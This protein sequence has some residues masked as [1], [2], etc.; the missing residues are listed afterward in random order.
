MLLLFHLFLFHC[1]LPSISRLQMVVENVQVQT[2][3][4]VSVRRE[5]AINIHVL[6][7]MV[8][9]NVYAS[10]RTHWISRSLSRSPD[11]AACQVLNATKWAHVYHWIVQVSRKLTFDCFNCNGKHAWEGESHQNRIRSSAGL[12][13]SYCAHWLPFLLAVTGNIS[14]ASLNILASLIGVFGV[15]YGWNQIKCDENRN[16]S[17]VEREDK[18]LRVYGKVKCLRK[19]SS[20]CFRIALFFSEYTMAPNSFCFASYKNL[21]WH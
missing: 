18:I 13:T 1:N 6:T 7:D 5:Y 9:E 8:R 17:W 16:R 15:I 2:K 11:V 4:A 21:Y 3:C 12:A 14:V 10:I 20:H 19:F